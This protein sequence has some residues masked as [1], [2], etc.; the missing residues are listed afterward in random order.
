MTI[1]LSTI[2]LK[3]NKL[4]LVVMYN[5]NDRLDTMSSLIP[6]LFCVSHK[7]VSKKTKKFFFFKFLKNQICALKDQEKN[8]HQ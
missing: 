2:I 7:V 5:V 4:I 8:Q 1:T 3:F 6:T